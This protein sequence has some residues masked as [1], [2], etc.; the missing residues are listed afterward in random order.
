MGGTVADLL[1][2]LG[3]SIRAFNQHDPEEMAKY[4]HPN[5]RVVTN[6]PQKNLL[7]AERGRQFLETQLKDQ[8]M[9]TLRSLTIDNQGIDDGAMKEATVTG[10]AH[11]HDKNGD[12]ELSFKFEAEFGKDPRDG[13][14]KWLFTEVSADTIGQ[15]RSKLR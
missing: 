7:I 9:F 11:W 1:T 6:H 8:P 3:G 5:E 15:E 10:K 13:E 14:E 4:Q 2:T 12:E